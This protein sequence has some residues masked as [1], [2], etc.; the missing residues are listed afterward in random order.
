[1][2][3]VQ[4]ILEYLELGYEVRLVEK[5]LFPDCVFLVAFLE[6]D[7]IPLECIDYAGK[8]RIECV[9]LLTD[10]LDYARSGCSFSF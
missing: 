6:D 9:T 10:L 1:M 8:S 2:S 4:N 5:P 3:I 7:E